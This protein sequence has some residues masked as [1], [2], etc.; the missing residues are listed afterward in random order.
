MSETIIDSYFVKLGELE[1][2][3][4]NILTT[5]EQLNTYFLD[6]E[7]ILNSVDNELDTLIFP[8]TTQHLRKLILLECERNNNSYIQSNLLNLIKIKLEYAEEYVN[9]TFP[10]PTETDINGELI[11]P[12]WDST[13]RFNYAINYLDSIKTIKNITNDVISHCSC[14]NN[15]KNIIANIDKL[16]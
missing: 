9:N 14:M 6:L 2:L 16:F 7:S 1:T 4:S 5:P 10:M 11:A 12:S 8:S 13:D 3:C 15:R